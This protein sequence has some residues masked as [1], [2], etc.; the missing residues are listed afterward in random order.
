MNV[1]SK[2]I[3]SSQKKQPKCPSLDECGKQIKCGRSVYSGTVFS[4]EKKK[5]KTTGTCYNVDEPRKHY[6]EWK[7]PEQKMTYYMIPLI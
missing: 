3:Q 4:H 7:K 2:I 1:P 6:A 5:Q